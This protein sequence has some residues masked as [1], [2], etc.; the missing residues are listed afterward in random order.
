M[1]MNEDFRKAVMLG[2]EGAWE[3]AREVLSMQPET[4]QRLFGKPDVEFIFRMFSVS[5]A[6]R[7][8][9]DNKKKESRFKSAMSLL[10]GFDLTDEEIDEFIRQLREK[11]D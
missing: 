4:R 2:A 5:E 8:I 7:I 1:G 3:Q 11:K 10:E 9:D 6:K